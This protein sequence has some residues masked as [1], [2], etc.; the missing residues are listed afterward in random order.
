MRK[1]IGWIPV[2][3]GGHDS[4]SVLGL[5][6]AWFSTTRRETIAGMKKQGLKFKIIPVFVE[7]SK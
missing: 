5:W 2:V 1:R 7:E 4:K 3:T 6:P